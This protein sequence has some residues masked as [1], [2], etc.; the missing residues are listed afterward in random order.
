MQPSP[1]VQDETGRQRA[2]SSSP[3]REQVPMTSDV[4][5]DEFGLEESALDMQP[6]DEPAMGY[7]NRGMRMDEQQER[8]PVPEP[9]AQP[10]QRPSTGQPNQQQGRPIRRL[11]RGAD[12]PRGG[13]N[14]PSGDVIDIPAFLRKR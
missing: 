9:E 10:S 5:E 8:L 6:T 14:V 2:I 13:R 7:G 11:D 12:I 1:Y 4:E 3:M